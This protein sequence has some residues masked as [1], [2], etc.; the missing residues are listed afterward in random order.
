MN[1]NSKY[2]TYRLTTSSF[3]GVFATLMIDPLSAQKHFLLNAVF[4]HENLSAAD[5]KRIKLLQSIKF[6]GSIYDEETI[7][8]IKSSM[9]PK[10][11][12]F[13]KS[14]RGLKSPVD[15]IIAWAKELTEVYES[16]QICI[17]MHQNRNGII[18][19]DEGHRI[20]PALGLDRKD[21]PISLSTIE[22]KSPMVDVYLMIIGVKNVP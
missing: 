9:I 2:S 15:R 13:T 10:F 14:F 16:N 3:P 11:V 6:E 8:L 4:K 21:S 22:G 7:E 19:L 5:K 1:E 12:V 17:R 20:R 18:Q